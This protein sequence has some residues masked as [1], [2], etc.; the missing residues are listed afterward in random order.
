MEK[1]KQTF[2]QVKDKA[3]SFMTPSNN[4]TKTIGDN[5]TNLTNNISNNKP[6]PVN[7]TNKSSKFV[8]IV[9]VFITFILFLV[10]YF[11]SKS[12][13]VSLT[14]DTHNIYQKYTTISSIPYEKEQISKLRLSD[15]SVASAYNSCL[16]GYQML[17]YVSLEVLEK[18]MQ[19]GARFVEFQI[20]NSE[21]GDESIPIVSNGYKGGEWKMTIDTV[22][23][24]DCAKVIEEH[25]FQIGDG[26]NGVPNPDDPLF[27]SLNLKTNH[28]LYCLDMLSDIIVDYFRDR[29]LDNKYS[30]QQNEI[31]DITME[32]LKGRVV[33]LSSEGFE[34]SKLDEVVNYSWGMKGMRRMHYSEIENADSRQI[35][36]Y[37]KRGITIVEPHKEGDFWTD[38]FDPQRAYDLGCQFVLMN[39]QHVDENMDKYIT[40]FR[41]NSIVAKPKKLRQDTKKQS[42]D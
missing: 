25:A 1:I 26:E 7:Q 31:A 27:I 36:A 15:V 33:I 17:D 14:L 40:K 38:N 29:L 22:S 37:N 32:E 34:G 21:Y 5:I 18:T 35:Q 42:K 30:Y 10:L 3:N 41:R 24:E 12:Y 6:N 13:R 2:Q 28:N 39:W 16:V 19:S 4:I 9:G 11:L 20:F 23:F 8:L